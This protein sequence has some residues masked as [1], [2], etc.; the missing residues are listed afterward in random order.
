MSINV[1]AQQAVIDA[2]CMDCKN[3]RKT[4][5][6]HTPSEIRADAGIFLST[7]DR[8]VE[9][10]TSEIGSTIAVFPNMSFV[11]RL[12]KQSL[13]EKFSVELVFGV[14]S[15]SDPC[16]L[17]LDIMNKFRTELGFV[18]KA[19]YLTD[20]PPGTFRQ[21]QAFIAYVVTVTN[22]QVES[23][24]L[25]WECRSGERF[26]TLLPK[27]IVEIPDIKELLREKGGPLSRKSTKKNGCVEVSS[28]GN[29]LPLTFTSDSRDRRNL[30]EAFSHFIS[31]LREHCDDFPASVIQVKSGVDWKAARRVERSV[32]FL[33][34]FDDAQILDLAVHLTQCRIDFHFSTPRIV[35]LDLNGV[36]SATLVRLFQYAEIPIPTS[37]TQGAFSVSFINPG[38]DGY[39]NAKADRELIKINVTWGRISAL[40][41]VPAQI[42]LSELQKV[43]RFRR[44]EDDFGTWIWD[45]LQGT[46]PQKVLCFD[47]E[48]NTDWYMQFHI[49]AKSERVLPTKLTVDEEAILVE[50]ARPYA[51]LQTG[52]IR[53]PAEETMHEHWKNAARLAPS[54]RKDRSNFIAHVENNFASLQRIS[55][56]QEFPISHQ[57]VS[58]IGTCEMSQFPILFINGDVTVDRCMC[59]LI[60]NSGSFPDLQ[61]ELQGAY[62]SYVQDP[63][64]P[65]DFRRQT[66]VAYVLSVC[67]TDLTPVN[68]GK[69]VKGSRG[70]FVSSTELL[71][72]HAYTKCTVAILLPRGIKLELVCTPSRHIEIL[73]KI[74][75]ASSPRQSSS[76]VTQPTSLGVNDTNVAE[77]SQ[78]LQSSLSLGTNKELPEPNTCL[79]SLPMASRRASADQKEKGNAINAKVPPAVSGGT[80][81]HANTP[82]G[83]HEYDRDEL[84][85][86]TATWP[87][88]QDTKPGSFGCPTQGPACLTQEV[89]P[90]EV[91][92]RD[93]LPKKVQVELEN[94]PTLAYDDEEFRRADDDKEQTLEVITEIPE[95]VNTVLGN[96]Q[97][98]AEESSP[99]QLITEGKRIITSIAQTL[100]KIAKVPMQENSPPPKPNASSQVNSSDNKQFDANGTHQVATYVANSTVQNE[101]LA[102]RPSV[103]RFEGIPLSTPFEENDKEVP[104][105]RRS[106]SVGQ[107][108]S[109]PNKHKVGNVNSKSCP[110]GKHKSS[111]PK[112]MVR[113]P[114][115]GGKDCSILSDFF[116]LKGGKAPVAKYPLR[117][118]GIPN[119]TVAV[120]EPHDVATCVKSRS[121]DVP[122]VDLESIINEEDKRIHELIL[123]KE[124]QIQAEAVQLVR[125][126]GEK[127]LSQVP[128]QKRNDIEKFA[129]Q[130]LLAMDST[131]CFFTVSLRMIALAP[132]KDSMVS[133]DVRQAAVVAISKGWFVKSDPFNAYPFT[134]AE[135]ALAAGSYLGKITPTLADDAT[136][137]LRAI[138]ELL[139]IACDEFF[140]QVSLA[141][142]FCQA[143]TVGAAPIFSTAVTWKSDDWVDLKTTLEKA[144]PFVSSF[145]SNWHAPTCDRRL[146]TNRC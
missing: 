37:I 24:D 50:H 88:K 107:F 142:P 18:S 14:N 87:L 111:P 42:K 32:L 5:L 132:W 41:S 49:P 102:A 108:P 67:S 114:S 9:L 146:C 139:P 81:P 94:P 65:N 122:M 7:Q 56:L 144:T 27:T 29:S 15:Y 76:I 36:S 20:L 96:C 145:P 21:K 118:A 85:T 126:A 143:K 72:C 35:V 31:Q 59:T 112:D 137:A 23:F 46:C 33:Q 79:E 17:A 116:L 34:S 64:I 101:I 66:P 55:L 28:S 129:V 63:P 45:A 141:C 90:S 130:F 120:K 26:E 109:T 140:A 131:L 13:H 70:L 104:K 78:H 2:L 74:P 44:E 43:E 77:L 93:D 95:D 16:M 100:D 40:T 113:K 48:S 89:K 11:R 105:A 22:E 103:S 124:H 75:V 6:C 127:W 61:N 3:L 99:V 92:N 136:V 119:P 83:R 106:Q 1:K 133:I 97:Q 80:G 69:V 25:L 134:R 91:D 98:E 4:V 53:P 68:I 47:E 117:R 52:S 10:F 8:L 51:F 54:D 121:T 57:G 60:E 115:K 30:R 38:E 86:P 73:A 71:K 125:D 138:V 39:S 12:C 84:I 58:Y 19:T 82:L 110:P 62:D 123:A 135:L 128:D